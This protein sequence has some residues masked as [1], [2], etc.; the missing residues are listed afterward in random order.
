MEPPDQP[1]RLDQDFVWQVPKPDEFALDKV[2]Q[3]QKV[4]AGANRK[5]PVPGSHRAGNLRQQLPS[6]KLIGERQVEVERGGEQRRRHS[7]H[8]Y[9]Q[10]DHDHHSGRR[11][12]SPDYVRESPCP[13]YG[14]TLLKNNLATVRDL[15][16]RGRIDTHHDVV[17][18]STDNFQR[19][20]LW[21]YRS[22]EW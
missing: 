21:C 10:S 6:A 16:T 3:D 15:I 22:I 13:T 14:D 7:I 12:G 1:G 2:E 8:S 19:R 4:W 9:A 18:E 11:D 17:R 5:A 20:V